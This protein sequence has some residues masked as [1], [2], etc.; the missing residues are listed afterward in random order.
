VKSLYSNVATYA[1]LPWSS[2]AGREFFTNANCSGNCT[3]MFAA[4][5]LATAFNVQRT[6]SLGTTKVVIPPSLSSLF[7]PQTCVSINTVLSVGNT[8]FTSIGADNLST[9]TALKSLFDRINNNE[10]LTCT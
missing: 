8:Y 2:S 3:S 5:F 10:A 9:T 4:Q 1:G 6:S 7:D